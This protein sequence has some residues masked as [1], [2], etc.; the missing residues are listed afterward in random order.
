VAPGEFIPVA[1][2]AG[3]IVPF[4]TWALREVCRQ[5]REWCLRFGE[6]AAVPIS[7]NLSARH[8]ARPG[9]IALVRE[10]LVE[11]GLP[12]R[13]LNLEITESVL[14]DDAASVAEV[15]AGLKEMGVSIA[16]DDFGTGFSCLSLL[17][18]FPIDTLKID[19]GFV[20]RIAGEGGATVRAIVALATN[21]EMDVV[22]EGVET[23][24]QLQALL[25][26]GCAYGQGYLFSR[27]L[28]REKAAVRLHRSLFANEDEPAPELVP[29]CA[30]C[31]RRRDEAGRWE[32]LPE[33]VGEDQK[34][35]GICPD[36]LRKQRSE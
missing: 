8:F 32:R 25:D 11:A 34:T 9:L 5:A 13:L 36:C 10:A 28:I 16:I 20:G 4:G 29:V 19:R 23:P 7:V 17:H 12:G 14:M 22:A 2:E 15:L 6:A 31:G 33:G 27:P 30:W 21:L 18:R 24:D 26:L 35:H 1:E 3:L